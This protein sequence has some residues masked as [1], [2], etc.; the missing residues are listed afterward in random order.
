[1]LLRH[2]RARLNLVAK[3]LHLPIWFPHVPL[4]ILLIVGGFLLLNSNFS[5]HWNEYFHQ[6]L[7]QQQSLSP[8]LLPP[9]LV[10]GGMLLMALGL[11]FRSRLAWIIA[12]LLVA[13]ATASVS[14]ESH[15]STLL[16]YFLFVLA[17]LFLCWRDFDRSSVAASTLFA[18]TSV[19]T[20]LGYATFGAYY[21]GKEF[22]PA[23]TDL[24]SAFYWAV[25]TMSTV[26]YGDISPK[27]AEAKLFTISVIVLGVAVFATALT[28]VIAPLVSRSLAR[29][30]NH[31][32][33]QMK[34][35]NHFIVIGNTSLATNTAKALQKR[36]Q[37]VTRLFRTEPEDGNEGDFDKV[38]GEPSNIEVLREA[39]AEQAEAVLAMLNDD[40]ENAFVVLAVRELAP[41]VETIVAV[42]DA[43]H[44]DRIKLVQPDVLI[45]PQVM[46]GELTAMLLSGETVTPDFVMRNVFERLTEEK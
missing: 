40:S 5:G 4:A 15:G 14:L 2:L 8:A 16:V 6:L 7:A 33:S 11:L 45:T 38:V 22:G 42:N 27:T 32:G 1:M 43:S 34:R 20:L 31:R 29:I 9:L 28:A 18:L 46:G 12:L 13:V 24:V 44:L 30:V 35:E 3:R 17:A 25:V 21:L 19:I 37:P 23:I 41:K 36:G 10:G 26:G 39:G